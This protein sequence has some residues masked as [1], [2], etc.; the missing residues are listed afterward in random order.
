MATTAKRWQ[1]WPVGV[2]K[3]DYSANAAKA[4]AVIS[5]TVPVPLIARYLGAAAG[6]VAAQAL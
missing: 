2:C 6:S 3:L 1:R 5:S 4:R